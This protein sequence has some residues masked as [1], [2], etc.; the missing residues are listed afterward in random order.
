MDKY[1]PFA[2][3]VDT[4]R[5]FLR[6]QVNSDVIRWIWREDVLTRR[7]PGSQSSWTRPIYV[8]PAAASNE[9]LVEQYYHIGVQRGFGVALCVLCIAAGQ[10]CCYIYIPDD[11]KDAEYRLMT[12]SVK[13][14][15]PSPP[16]TATIAGSPVWRFFLRRCIGTPDNNWIND[17]PSRI[18]AA[19]LLVAE[20]G[21]ANAPRHRAGGR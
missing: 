3:A 19:R 10:A 12:G 6:S 13:F 18:S 14:Q 5:Q 15:I 21:P 11:E 7:A 8:E 9:S 1:P 2:S 4:F 20:G 16:P 17:V